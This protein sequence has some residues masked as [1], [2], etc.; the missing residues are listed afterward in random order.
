MSRLTLFAA[1]LFAAAA[2]TLPTRVDGQTV[3]GGAIRGTVT[4]AADSTPV[5]N[6]SVEAR[7]SSN[8]QVFR[9]RA[10]MDGQ[11]VMEN[12]PVE[13]TYV[14]SVRMLGYGPASRA[15]LTVLLGQSIGADFR[16]VK[17]AALLTGVDVVAVGY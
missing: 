16:L 12:L 11:Y 15:D 7:N 6:A 13:G 14:V 8:G 4:N 5:P 3:R 17:Q 9:A 10:G 2:G 1:A